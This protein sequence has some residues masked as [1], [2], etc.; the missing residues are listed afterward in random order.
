MESASLY[1]ILSP[2]LFW[3]SCYLCRLCMQMSTLAVARTW[4]N[5]THLIT[6]LRYLW[7]MPNGV[8]LSLLA[9]EDQSPQV[10]VHNLKPGLKMKVGCSS[11]RHHL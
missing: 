5:V 7:F 6:Y 10:V 1:A 3:A 8:V 2:T 4:V 9:N 11:I